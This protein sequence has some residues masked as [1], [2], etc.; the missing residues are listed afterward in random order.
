VADMSSRAV[1]ERLRE[2]GSLLA[3]RGFV[4]KGVPMSRAAVTARLRAL[5]TLSDACRRLVTVGARLRNAS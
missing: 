3:K 5:G 2:V 1:T 4:S